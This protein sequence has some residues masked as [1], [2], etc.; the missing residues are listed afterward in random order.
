MGEQAS[1]PSQ[2]NIRFDDSTDPLEKQ[3]NHHWNIM[4]VLDPLDCCRAD[5]ISAIHQNNAS[6]HSIVNLES[7]I[8]LISCSS[9]VDTENRDC[10]HLYSRSTKGVLELWPS[11]QSEFLSIFTNSF[12][13]IFTNLY[14]NFNWSFQSSILMDL[15]L[16][17]WKWKEVCGLRV[18][19]LCNF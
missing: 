14:V 3:R 17:S 19:I 13:L 6:S 12:E 8:P 4:S 18:T 15:Q 11:Q 5:M 7:T 9:L 1:V 2:W 16:D 10:F